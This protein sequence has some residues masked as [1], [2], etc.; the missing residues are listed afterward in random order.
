MSRL[1]FPFFLLTS[2]ACFGQDQTTLLDYDFNGFWPSELT[3]DYYQYCTEPCN[4]NGIATYDSTLYDWRIVNT[5]EYPIFNDDFCSL[6]GTPYIVGG[7]YD[8]GPEWQEDGVFYTTSLYFPAVNT[9]GY[10]SLFLS[11]EIIGYWQTS[12]NGE[13]RFE[14][15]NDSGES[16]FVVWEYVGESGSLGNFQSCIPAEHTMDISAFQTESLEL[17]IVHQNWRFTAIDNV[18]IVGYSD[19]NAIFG[20]SDP[21]ACNYDINVTE[22]D[23]SCTYPSEEY[24]DCNGE[25]LNDS[26]GDGVC[27]ELELAGC[28][29][30]EACNYDQNATDDDGTCEYGLPL[31]SIQ[32]ELAPAL[33][34]T[35]QY[36][37][38]ITDGSSYDWS[39]TF[40]AI[41]SGNGTSTVEVGWGEIGI[42]ELCVIE[43]SLDG[44]VGD[45]VCAAVFITPLNIEEES[46][47]EFE[48]F[49]NPASTSITISTNAA[50]LSS[51]Y[52]ITDVQGKLVMEGVLLNT[53]TVLNTDQLSNGQYTL[54]IINDEAV[55]TKPLIIQK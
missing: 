18:K 16:W 10:D 51:P 21:M 9:L 48:V 52:R 46:E 43:T 55:I 54:A 5:L 24:L 17:K 36:T 34:E 38:Q 30:S 12:S 32:G 31:Y 23:G 22:D 28:T 8:L 47:V 33:F 1:L 13:A 11:F 25:C 6:N 35:Q 27:D 49:P 29:D 45:Q 3:V 42:G 4:E 7:D 14:V 53:T 2:V 50:L 44:C 41:I 20:C 37:Y 19:L 40:G 26:D 15:S 39:A